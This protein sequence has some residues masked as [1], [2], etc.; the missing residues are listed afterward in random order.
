MVPY[1]DRQE[2][3]Q[4][5]LAAL[6]TLFRT[7]LPDNSFYQTK[8]AELK[9]E[10]AFNS[11]EDFQR[12]VPFTL[13]TDLVTDQISNPPYGSNLT[14]PLRDYVRYNQT[15]GTS[16]Q[17][18]RWLDTAESWEWMLRGWRRI[19]LNCS[20][21]AG[22]RLGFAFSFGPFLGFWT[23]FDA[24]VQ[25]GFLCIP[26]GGLSSIARLKLFQQN[27]IDALLCTPTYAIRLGEIAQTEGV[28][29]KD[30]PVRSIIVAGEPGGSLPEVVRRIEGLWPGARVYDHHGM[31]EVG[32]VSYECPE[33]RGTLRIL[34]DNYFAE[35]LDTQT[36]QPVKPGEPGEL[37][38][39]TLGRYGSPLIRYRTGD[40]VQENTSA[41]GDNPELALQGGILGRTDDMCSI[42][43]VN[44]YPAAIDSI[45]RKF[46][47]IAEYQV[48]ISTSRGMHE[49]AIK[50]EPFPEHAGK[51]EL[52]TTLEN[53]LR[54]QLTL[55]MPVHEV[56]AGELPRF[57][58]KARR[59]VIQR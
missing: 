6:N 45:L 23:A 41:A 40:L 14:R 57:E 50:V 4:E 59:W 13:K 51:Q 38:L 2:M 53:E 29:F 32:P 52:L 34:S 26:A 10:D 56:G 25:L 39:T 48:N 49:M 15:S 43:G 12:R 22:D 19:H 20:L 9:E 37:V 47:W 11:I 8:F 44:I 3:Q 27:Q 35:V 36:R 46:D 33:N 18:L 55:R 7:I 21:K 28:E 42:R 58:M 5:Q 1:K 31:T 17:P 54:A 16:G 30:H 24:A